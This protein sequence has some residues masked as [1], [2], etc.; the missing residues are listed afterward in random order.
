MQKVTWTFP[1]LD[2]SQNYETS[3]AIQTPPDLHMHHTNGPN[4]NTVRKHNSP[5][6]Q[7]SL[8]CSIADTKFVLYYSRTV[9]PTLLIALNK[10]AT[11]QAMPTQRTKAKV[12]WLLD[13][14]AT[15]PNAK[16]RFSKSDMILYIDSDAAYLVLP[17]TPSRFAGHF[18]LSSAADLSCPSP[19][20]NSPIH[21]ECKTIWNADA[22]AVDAKTA[23]VFGNSQI[24]IPIL[25]ALEAL[26]HPQPPT[27]IKTNSSTVHGTKAPIMMP[28]I[29]LS[30][31]HP[32][33]I[34]QNA[35]NSS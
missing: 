14:T 12:Q 7:I 18:Y 31:T 9:D 15:Y 4:L 30:T 35:Q 34:D 6:S 22:S 19:P 16:N 2:I 32:H 25:R 8:L 1:C 28:T 3:L 13:Y 17:N 23:G 29:I 5:Q 21:T 26:N 10:I 27:P 24:A 33:T 20:Q 11:S